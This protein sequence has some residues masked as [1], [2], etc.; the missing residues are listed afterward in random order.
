[1]IQ[2][3]RKTQHYRIYTLLY[4]TRTREKNKKEKGKENNQRQIKD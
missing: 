2:V 3:N 1:M 4:Y